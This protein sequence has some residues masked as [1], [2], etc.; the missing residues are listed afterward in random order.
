M[1]LLCRSKRGSSSV[2][3]LKLRLGDFAG[4]QAARADAHALGVTL[5]IGRADRLEVRQEAALGDTGRV[6]TDAAFVL[7]RTLADNHVTRRRT[8]AANVTN[9]GHCLIPFV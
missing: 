3:R 5:A 4:L 1:S 9:S 6:Q 7:G 2:L 8:L